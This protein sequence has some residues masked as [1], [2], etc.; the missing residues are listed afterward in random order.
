MN[1]AMKSCGLWRYRT[2]IL[3][4]DTRWRWVISFTPRTFNLLRKSPQYPLYW[5]LVVSPSR[6]GCCHKEKNSLPLSGIELQI[7]D[8]R[9]RR[10]V[11]LWRSFITHRAVSGLKTGIIRTLALCRS[12]FL[13]QLWTRSLLLYAGTFSKI[14]ALTLKQ[15]L[16]YNLAACSTHSV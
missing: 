15:Y 7:L 16:R 12:A 1:C 5:R 2:I 13:P 10:L 4:L 14:R 9:A 3:K 6:S 8:H 11:T